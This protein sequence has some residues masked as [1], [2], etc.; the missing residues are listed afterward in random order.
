MHRIV[1]ECTLIPPW[2]SED[3]HTLINSVT[4]IFK[5]WFVVTSNMATSN[6]S[7]SL[8][9]SSP[10]V[11][12]LCLFLLDSLTFQMAMFMTACTYLHT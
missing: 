11:I 10:I 6:G 3:C 5:P 9:N 12:L 2:N 1:L 7:S 8:E 4:N